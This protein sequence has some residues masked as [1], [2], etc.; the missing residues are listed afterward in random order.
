MNYLTFSEQFNIR[1]YPRRNIIKAR[2]VNGPITLPCGVLDV[3]STGINNFFFAWTL[4]LPFFQISL[5][6]CE[7]P[8]KIL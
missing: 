2:N 5:T 7:C 1:V 8:R 4:K 3:I 6:T